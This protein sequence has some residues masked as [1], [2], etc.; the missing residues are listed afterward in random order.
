MILRGWRI[1]KSRFAASAFTG[2][3]ARRFGGRWSSPGVSV[4]YVAGSESLAILEMLV[5][6]EAPDF[7]KRYVLFEVTFDHRLVI[8]VDDARLPSTWRRSPPPYSIQSVGDQWVASGKSA[9]LRLPSA[10]AASEWNYMLNP[11]HPDFAKI[12]IGPRRPVRLDA[13]FLKPK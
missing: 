10:L 1:V 6:L 12:R 5:H 9:V 11:A 8:R 7:L 4:V 13:R 2:E 3:G